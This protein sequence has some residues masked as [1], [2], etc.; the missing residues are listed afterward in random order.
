M[1][2][3][4]EDFVTAV[5][6]ELAHDGSYRMLSCGHPAPVRVHGNRLEELPCHPD[7]PLGLGSKPEITCGRLDP[8]DRLVLF[9]DGLVEARLQD[10][11]FVDVSDVLGT[12]ATSEFDGALDELLDRLA[13]LVGDDL[14]DD[15]A[16]V[17]AE[18]DPA[19]QPASAR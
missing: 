4:E 18:F 5:V 14:G 13:A 11:R 19:A 9:T 12:L 8:G 6:V 15:L 1:H 3:G 10:R 7:V 2:L 16:L 17:L